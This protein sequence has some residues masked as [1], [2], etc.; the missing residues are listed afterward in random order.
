LEQRLKE[1]IRE[2]ARKPF[3]TTAH[4]R[5]YIWEKGR[6]DWREPKKQF[7]ISLQEQSYATRVRD[8]FMGWIVWKLMDATPIPFTTLSSLSSSSSL[9]PLQHGLFTLIRLCYGLLTVIQYMFSFKY[10]TFYGNYCCSMI[11]VSHMMRFD[12]FFVKHL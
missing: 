10:D 5:L 8:I 11:Q 9:I 2:Q 12:A 3:L 4:N 1:K 6:W 7:A